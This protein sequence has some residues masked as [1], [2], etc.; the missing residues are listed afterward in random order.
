MPSTGGFGL[1]YWPVLP[2]ALIGIWRLAARRSPADLCLLWWLLVYPVP[3]ALT[4][5][6]HPDWLRAACGMGVW[7]LVAGAGV[8]GAVDWLRLRASPA[9][10]RAGVAILAALVAVNAAWFLWDYS[11]RFP[12]RAAWAFTDGA[13]EAMREVARREDAYGHIVLPAQVPAVHD[14]YLFYT[15][16][17]PARLHHEGLEDVAA[18]GDWAEVRRF[19]R[20]RVCDP[21]ICCRPGDLC[22]VRGPWTGPGE[23]LAEVRDRSGRVAFS[24]IAGR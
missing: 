14:L 6:A 7:E 8:V 22:L 13:S 17:E 19:G 2:F 16:Y 11:R 1:L 5:G 3:A 9:V 15:R 4:R 18:P 24:L 20:H 10:L 23:L 21:A 12:V